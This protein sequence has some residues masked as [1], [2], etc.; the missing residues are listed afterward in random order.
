MST[1]KNWSKGKKYNTFNSDKVLIHVPRW[2]KIFDGSPYIPPPVSLDVDISNIC[3]LS[4][5]WCNATS[6]IDGRASFISSKSLAQLADFL[7]DWGAYTNSALPVRA[8]VLAGGGEPLTNPNFSVFVERL[9]MNGISVGVITNGLL[10]TKH[11][12]A[13]SKCTWVGVSVDCATVETYAKLKNP[14]N[15]DDFYLVVDHIHEL[16]SFAK[17]FKTRLNR[18]NLSSG[19]TY[20][21]LIHRDNVREVFEATELAKRLGCKSIYFRPISVPW[22]RLNEKPQPSFISSRDIKRFHKNIDKAMSLDCA[23]FSVYAALDKFGVNFRSDNCFTN[24]YGGFV[25]AVIMPP[26][27]KESGII[28]GLCCDRRGDARMEL[29]EME[30]KDIEKNWGTKRHREILRLVDVASCPRCAR[31]L[32]NNVIQSVILEDSMSYNFI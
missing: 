1:S 27:K 12:K 6:V 7:P 17:E 13:L 21:Y 24:C 8:V 29:G 22:N 25:T 11:L 15:S 32:H 23:S 18:N 30:V 4:C 19:V 31:K 16:I 10:I 9:I 20:K 26:R 3:N 28:L 5:S 14:N 2:T